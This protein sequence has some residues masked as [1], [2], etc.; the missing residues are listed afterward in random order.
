MFSKNLINNSII[1][2]KI[3]KNE[4]KGFKIFFRSLDSIACFETKSSF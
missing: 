4:E 3:V 1:K 2:Y